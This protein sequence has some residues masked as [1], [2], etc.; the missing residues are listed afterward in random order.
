MASSEFLLTPDQLDHLRA[1]LIGYAI[2]HGLTYAAMDRMANVGNGS[3]GSVIRGRPTTYRFVRRLALGLPGVVEDDLLS[4]P[5]RAAVPQVVP[6]EAPC[7]LFGAITQMT[8]I[9]QGVPLIPVATTQATLEIIVTLLR[10]GVLLLEG[11]QRDATAMRE[12]TL[13]IARSEEL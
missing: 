8:E 7:E 9:P 11:I 2:D 1:M 6:E 4:S 13:S 12:W 3:I 10:E 5:V